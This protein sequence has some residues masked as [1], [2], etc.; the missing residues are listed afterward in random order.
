MSI[1][2]GVA[3]YMAISDIVHRYATETPYGGVIPVID[4]AQTKLEIFLDESKLF[5]DLIIDD[6]V[7]DDFVLP[8]DI[9]NGF[10]AN[11]DY[12]RGNMYAQISQDKIS[13]IHAL[14]MDM[15]PGGRSRYLVGKTTI[16]WNAE[17]SELQMTMK[18]LDETDGNDY[19]DFRGKVDFHGDGDI[20][21][22]V[23][24]A[25]F[26]DWS[27]DKYIA[28]Q[29]FSSSEVMKSLC[30]NKNHHHHGHYK[31]CKNIPKA[32]AGIKSMS[33]VKDQII[34]SAHSHRVD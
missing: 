32:I 28:E 2:A 13:V 30:E 18:P 34:V 3:A 33:S 7:P 12:L 14:P 15:F 19:I 8:V 1:I 9:M 29:S 24:T 6:Q 17:S 21:L 31:L 16:F 23:L 26:L 20:I 11:S 25:Q 4:I 10:I 22:K 5:M 27:L